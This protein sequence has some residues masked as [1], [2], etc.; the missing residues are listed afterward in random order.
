MATNEMESCFCK[1]KDSE[2]GR[3]LFK[4]IIM[5]FA[6]RNYE[7]PRIFGIRLYGVSA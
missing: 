6:W 4:S 1:Y 5:E 3:G 2:G 7:K